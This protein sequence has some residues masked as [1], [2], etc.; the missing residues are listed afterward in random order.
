TEWAVFA[1]NISTPYLNVHSFT[2]GNYAELYLVN[3]TYSV[4]TVYFNSTGSGFS[5]PS[6]T[7]NVSKNTSVLV[8]FQSHSYYINFEESGLPPGTEWSVVLDGQSETS[9]TNMITVQELNGSFPYYVGSALRN[10]TPAGSTVVYVPAPSDGIV[11]V[12]GSSVSVMITF[13]PSIEMHHYFNNLTNIHHLQEY[14]EEKGQIGYDPII[15][16]AGTNLTA[17]GYSESSGTSIFTENSSFGD[18]RNPVMINSTSYDFY[19]ANSVWLGKSTLIELFK[20]GNS[21]F[22]SLY[23]LYNPTS[24]VNVSSNFDMW[25]YSNIVGSFNGDLFIASINSSFF[26][27]GLFEYNATSLTYEHNLTSLIPKNLEL[28]FATANGENVLFYGYEFYS[29]AAVP[30]I[31]ILNVSTG[32]Y[33]NITPIAPV[34]NV[35]AGLLSGLYYN[36]DFVFSGL[37]YNNAT[38]TYSPLLISYNV[39]TNKITNVSNPFPSGYGILNMTEFGNYVILS[40]FSINGSNV[41]YSYNPR[42]DTFSNI[43]DIVGSNLTITSM[44]SFNGNLY[45][46]GTNFQTSYSS[47]MEFSPNFSLVRSK[48]LSLIQPYFPTDW[49][50]NSYYG[51]NGFITVGGNGLSFYNG[52]F[53]SPNSPEGGIPLLPGYLTAAAWDGNGFLVVGSTFWYSTGSGANLRYY[54]TGPIIGMYYPNNNTLVNLDNLIPSW[55]DKNA[56]FYQVTWN[57]SDF[58]ILGEEASN[59]SAFWWNTI[60]FSYNTASG[61]LKEIMGPDAA[62]YA[63]LTQ[64]IDSIYYTDASL[65]NSANGVGILD[66]Q[67]FDFQSILGE[68]DA[69][70]GNISTSNVSI[71][72]EIGKLTATIASINATITGILANLL[73]IK[74]GFASISTTLSSIKSTLGN[75]NGY[76]SNLTAGFENLQSSFASINATF[77][78]IVSNIVV[79]EVTEGVIK[80]EIHNITSILTNISN[81]STILSTQLGQIQ[82]HLN[83]INASFNSLSATGS[84]IGN[85]TATIE[86]AVG[87]LYPII[88]NMTN[89]FST[90]HMTGMISTSYGTFILLYTYSGTVLGL[91][92]GNTIKE[93]PSVVPSDLIVNNWWPYGSSMAYGNGL[94]FVSGFNS[95]NGMLFAASYNPLT[96]EVHNYSNLLRGYSGSAVNSVG[97]SNG[98]FLIY[99]VEYTST[100]SQE[101]LLL[102]LNPSANEVYNISSF[103]PKKFAISSS[104]INSMASLDGSLY[105]TGGL[106]GNIYYGILNLT[107]LPI[108][109][110]SQSITYSQA[111]STSILFYSLSESQEFTVGGGAQVVPVNYVSIYLSGSGTAEFGIGNSLW[112]NS[113]LSNVTVNVTHTGWYN[114][115]FNTVYLTQ[116]TDYFLNVYDVSGSVTWG[117]TSSPSISINAL[118]EYYYVSGSLVS[119]TGSPDLFSIGFYTIS[120]TEYSVT[121]TESGLPAGTS[122]SVTLNGVTLSSSSNSIVFSEP[123]GSYSYT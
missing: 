74:N 79:S 32:K 87:G 101:S 93:L 115:S 116:G 13:R 46:A 45:I 122:W 85:D 117:F 91:L 57:G 118:T 48:S 75:I 120:P 54:N 68:I 110:P 89:A 119:S 77:T 73:S 20:F 6:F 47:E 113:I 66:A 50:A 53:E 49:V 1:S 7:L 123:N 106:W 16:P 37:S 62:T 64:V 36:R 4:S 27:T 107:Q 51:D 43:T 78:A 59:A 103:I 18:I 60:L 96:G 90:A 15:T 76:T 63:N 100:S 121:F 108:I 9:T 83:N 19:P 11:T 34:S 99:G 58:T 17:Y 21:S 84:T 8:P 71:T 10:T 67:T 81:N 52:T 105:F 65:S 104:N 95:S 30:Y 24:I 12:S 40:G 23:F 112:N 55:L 92:N 33:Q 3:G 94:L 56:S 88:A 72:T 61:E 109:Y 38:K 69:A 22:R 44:N 42:N 82:S 14:Q 97:Y 35:T 2:D 26:D 70:F 29:N 102:A 25:N 39:S 98:L 5:G 111:N 31:G 86:S 80:T 41:L 28:S 114:I